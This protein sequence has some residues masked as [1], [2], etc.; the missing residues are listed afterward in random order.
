MKNYMKFFALIL[1]L[2]M[3]FACLAGCGGSQSGEEATP[4]SGESV[5][6]G[7]MVS[8]LDGLI[9]TDEELGLAGKYENFEDITDGS[10]DE[11]LVGKWQSA[12][13]DLIYEYGEDGTAKATM[14]QYDM[15]NE[16]PYTCVKAGDKNV[17]IEKAEYMD[18][19]DTEDQ[20]ALSMSTYKV[21]GDVLYMTTVE[22]M[23][24][25][26]ITSNYSSLIVLFRMDENGNVMGS[27]AD[28]YSMSALNGDWATE[29][30][31]KIRI[32]DD[33]II[34]IGANLISGDPMPAHFDENGKFVIEANGTETAYNFGIAQMKNYPDGRDSATAEISYTMSLTY[35]GADENDVPNIKTAMMDWKKEYDYSDYYYSLSASKPKE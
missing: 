23:S 34:I 4:E 25:P 20:F 5:E 31:L 29:E 22:D 24:D 12:D 13:G 18:G 30:G 1:A 21:A 16:V 33:S 8:E 35:T 14:V 15:V 10:I 19:S 11:A 9:S 2:V 7:D 26:N 17:I 27:A 32:A 28:V 3:I 6:V